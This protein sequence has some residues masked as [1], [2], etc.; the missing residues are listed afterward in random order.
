MPRTGKHYDLEQNW[1]HD[2]RRDILE[3]TKAALDYL[4]FLYEMH[5]DW[6]LALASYNWGEG[7]VKR[8]VARNRKAHKPTD[9]ASLKMPRETRN[10]IPKLQPLKNII[11][12]PEP[13][14]IDLYPIPN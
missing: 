10:Y 13:Y 12:D 4:T 9:Y 5:G 1:W 6:H 7:S 3:S 8:A 11:A 2:E 14:G